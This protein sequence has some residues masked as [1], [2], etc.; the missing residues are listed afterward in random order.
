[1]V[2]EDQAPLGALKRDGFRLDIAAAFVEIRLSNRNFA[3]VHDDF[4]RGRLHVDGDRDGSRV[5]EVVQVGLE[6]QVIMTREHVL[7]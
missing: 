7:R 1:M 4:L 5:G 2:P 3:R 6:S